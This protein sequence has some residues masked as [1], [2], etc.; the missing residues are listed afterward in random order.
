[1][2]N[3]CIQGLKHYFRMKEIY[4]IFFNNLYSPL[5]WKTEFL[6]PIRELLHPIRLR[7]IAGTAE[8]NAPEPAVSHP[9]SP[10]TSFTLVLQQNLQFLCLL[11]VPRGD[12]GATGTPLISHPALAPK[13]L[14]GSPAL[15][16][17]Q[18]T[19]VSL[20]PKGLCMGKNLSSFFSLRKLCKAF[21]CQNSTFVPV[22]SR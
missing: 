22:L 10:S 8:S 5:A 9:S 21:L 4:S 7:Y 14:P 1:M 16:I 20:R 11:H 3:L 17:S 18:C 6:F 12:Q 19:F 13:T 15:I 2:I